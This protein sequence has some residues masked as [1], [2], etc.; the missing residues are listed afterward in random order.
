MIVCNTVKHTVSFRF[1]R[2][3]ELMTGKL[4]LIE[5]QA[6]DS[7]ADTVYTGIKLVA[8]LGINVHYESIFFRATN[9]S[10]LE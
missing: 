7:Y 6:L 2:L 5:W 1:W 9:Y 8:K 3:D 10:L 4:S